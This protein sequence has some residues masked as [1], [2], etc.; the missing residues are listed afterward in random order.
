LKS[1]ESAKGIQG[2]PSVF[3]WFSLD[4]FALD[5]PLGCMFCQVRSPVPKREGEAGLRSSLFDVARNDLVIPAQAGIQSL[6]KIVLDA[7]FRGH[8][9]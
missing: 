2:N 8:D 5:S 6:G 4:L 7:R 1:P 9:S 3:S